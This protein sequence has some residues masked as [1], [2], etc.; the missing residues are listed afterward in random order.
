MH[1]LERQKVYLIELRSRTKTAHYET[2]NVWDGSAAFCLYF[3]EVL[4][5]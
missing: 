4:E 2:G 5:V 3:L 1:V